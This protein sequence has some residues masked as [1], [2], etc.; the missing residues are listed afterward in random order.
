MS[1]AIGGHHELGDERVP[2]GVSL[3]AP[4]RETEMAPQRDAVVARAAEEF[5]MQADRVVELLDDAEAEAVEVA[6]MFV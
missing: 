1:A 2:P 4:F 6:S 3:A 5:G